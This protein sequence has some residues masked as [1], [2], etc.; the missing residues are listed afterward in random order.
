MKYRFTL[1]NFVDTLKSL[2]NQTRVGAAMT[3]K[4]RG[5][6]HLSVHIFF[7]EIDPFWMATSFSYKLGDITLNFIPFCET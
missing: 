2:T 6:V 7:L 1:R 5:I 3:E 4:K